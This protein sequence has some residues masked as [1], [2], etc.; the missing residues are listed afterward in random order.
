MSK[1]KAFVLLT[2]PFHLILGECLL[3]NRK[4]IIKIGIIINP[5]INE[6]S[7]NIIKFNAKILGYK[8]ILDLRSYGKKIFDFERTKL[9]VKLFNQKK[10]NFYLKKKNLF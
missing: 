4:N 3:F 9:F 1:K 5:T 6:N 10:F 7:I 2:N 8:K